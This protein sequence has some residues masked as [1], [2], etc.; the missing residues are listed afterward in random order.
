M[1]S[2]REAYGLA[3]ANLGNQYDFY[4][5]DADLSKATQTVQFAKKFPERFLDMGIAEANMM[6]FAAGMSTCGVPVV[7]STFAAFAAGR[8]YDQVRNGIAYPDCN[9]KIGA[10]HGG[11]MIGADGGSHQCVEDIALMRAIPNMTVLCPCDEFETYA[12]VKAA[13][14]Y[15][16]P[17]YLRFGRMP[18]PNIY[19]E[20][21]FTFQIGKGTVISEGEDVTLIGI[22]DMVSRCFEAAMLLAKIGISA[23]VIDMA[24]V[25][26]IDEKLIISFAKRTGCIV[27][28]EDHNIIGG[29]GGAVSELL[30]RNYPIPVENIGIQDKFGKSGSPEELAEYFGLTVEKIVEASKKV[31]GRKKVIQ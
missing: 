14:E 11:V 12:C 28:A 4:V 13:I 20:G 10:T 30:V 15:Q 27:T 8:A 26:P 17:V 5:L 9:V 19:T 16:G 18:S 29:L 24:S 1:L 2:T 7:A 21:G 22:G 3:L 6:D 31:I 23:A 25:K